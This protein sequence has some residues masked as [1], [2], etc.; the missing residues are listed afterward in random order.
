MTGMGEEDGGWGM[1]LAF[2]AKH[3]HPER[4]MV[5]PPSPSLVPH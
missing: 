3:C 4:S 5:I 1:G 2:P